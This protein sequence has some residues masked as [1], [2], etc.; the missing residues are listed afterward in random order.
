MDGSG[1]AGEHR[2]VQSGNAYPSPARLSAPLA[3]CVVRSPR[4]EIVRIPIPRV[5]GHPLIGDATR[6][7]NIPQR[8]A[9]AVE[10]GI[11]MHGVTRIEPMPE[12]PPPV[13]H[14][15]GAWMACN[16]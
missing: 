4:P 11:M 6:A 8:M 15:E 7:Q 10:S 3:D 5:A 13:M 12:H 1:Q 14:N 9:I 16:S 2:N